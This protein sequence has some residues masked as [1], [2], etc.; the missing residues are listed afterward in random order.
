M[1]VA[2][3]K[4]ELDKFTEEYITAKMKQGEVVFPLYFHDELKEKFAV[5][6]LSRL[7]KAYLAGFE[8][9]TDEDAAMQQDYARVERGDF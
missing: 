7:T 1:D 9:G 3:I 5:W 2:A 8:A 6:M 4:K